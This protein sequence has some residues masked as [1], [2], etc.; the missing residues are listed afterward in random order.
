MY[1]F[2]LLMV[3]HFSFKAIV[4]TDL[5]DPH[6]FGFSDY[7]HPQITSLHFMVQWKNPSKGCLQCG[8]GMPINEDW[9]SLG[10][11]AVRGRK[12]LWLFL[13]KQFVQSITVT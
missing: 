5:S 6:S 9:G 2:L 7:S 1:P 13:K 4:A 10:P 11:A 8:A 12:A 3:K